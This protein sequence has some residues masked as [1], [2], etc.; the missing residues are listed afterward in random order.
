[1]L[2]NDNYNHRFYSYTV[3]VNKITKS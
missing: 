2:F 3:T 1:M